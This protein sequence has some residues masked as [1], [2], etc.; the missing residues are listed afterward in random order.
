MSLFT[1][2]SEKCGK[3]A[4]EEFQAKVL[5][6]VR[7]KNYM[8]LVENW[9]KNIT[10]SKFDKGHYDS[11]YA[12][13]HYAK[14]IYQYKELE[15]MLYSFSCNNYEDSSLFYCLEGTLRGNELQALAKLT[16]CFNQN[17]NHFFEATLDDYQKEMMLLKERDSDGDGLSDYDE[18][19]NQGTDPFIVD[20]DRDGITDGEEVAIG[21]DPLTHDL[22]Q[23][24]IVKKIAEAKQKQGEDRISQQEIRKV[25][26]QEKGQKPVI[27]ANG[28]PYQG[29]E[30][31]VEFSR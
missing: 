17:K 9:E 23:K 22:K 10:F 8:D 30:S 21:T 5:D 4:F 3:M 19:Y 29:K 24:S 7:Q 27:M 26:P 31:M 18:R 15:I 20:T 16:N 25:Q 6:K 12:T 13:I 14:E 28:K 11:F 1:E 2:S